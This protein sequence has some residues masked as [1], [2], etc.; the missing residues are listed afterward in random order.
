MNERTAMVAAWILFLVA[1]GWLAWLVLND[2]KE[3]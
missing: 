3:R 1:V 2:D